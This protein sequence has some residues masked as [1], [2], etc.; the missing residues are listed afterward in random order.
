MVFVLDD[1]SKTLATEKL[2]SMAVDRI[3]GV[4]RIWCKEGTKLKEN[5]LRVIRKNIMKFNAKTAYI[6]YWIGNHMESNVKSLCVSE[7]TWK[8]KQLEVEGGTYASAP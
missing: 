6:F 2:T 7:V 5:N 1:Q 3:S 8:M 4:A